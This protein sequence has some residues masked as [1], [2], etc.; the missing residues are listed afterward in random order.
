MIGSSARRILNTLNGLWH[1]RAVL[2]LFAIVVAHWGEHLMQAWQVYV[3]HWSL[4]H[5]H[6]GIGLLFPWLIT[7]EWLH[8]GYVGGIFAGLLLVRQ[9][10]AG[11]ARVWWNAAVLVQAWHFLEH[12]LLLGQAALGHNLFGAAVPTSI[13]QLVVP[14]LELHLFYNA[15]G[16]IPMVMGL[17]YH[18]FPPAGEKPAACA[19]ALTKARP[20][21]LRY[22]RFRGHAGNGRGEMLPQRGVATGV[23]R[24]PLSRAGVD[25][26]QG[27]KSRKR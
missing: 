3:R 10:F 22:P 9:G 7:S 12:S 14:R 21:R 6:G 25:R 8:Y 5:A 11:H 23:S 19:C 18:L 20:A 27:R 24:T 15:I 2:I 17:V 16:F 1:T 26:E 4:P 13:L